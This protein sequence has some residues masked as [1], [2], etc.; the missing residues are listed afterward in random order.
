MSNRY[1]LLY[2]DHVAEVQRRW[3]QAL[4]AE[5]FEAVLV[6]S[7][8]PISSFLDDYEYAFRPNPHF[9]H[10]LPLTRHAD[11]ALLVL[12]GRQPTLF[13]FQPDD[14]WHLPP[15]DPEAWWADRFRI[16]I[17]RDADGA[18]VA[19]ASA[20][21]CMRYRNAEMT[22]FATLP[23]QRGL[24]LAQYLLAALE[25]DME[26][27][28]IPNLYT[29]ARARSAGM[30]RVFYNR[31]YEMTGTLVNNCHIAGQFEDMHVWCRSG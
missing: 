15:A 25:D 2:T 6:H 29:I 16:E 4:E 26:E 7:G 28:E 23:S 1:E 27:A 12:P 13:Y 19:A 14:Y 17:V 18:L 5:Q 21:T 9:L 30:N 11:S 24:G 22:D 31:G 20:E 3:E 10:W 8:T